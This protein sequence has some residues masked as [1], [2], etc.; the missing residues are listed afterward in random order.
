MSNDM[1][2]TW[3]LRGFLFCLIFV[4]ALIATGFVDLVYQRV[5]ARLG[6]IDQPSM[7]EGVVFCVVLYRGIWGWLSK[8]VWI[9]RQSDAGGR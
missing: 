9:G 2:K 1:K 6:W 8:R 7:V 5:T 4:V 3:A